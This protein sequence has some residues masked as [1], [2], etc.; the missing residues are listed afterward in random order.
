[1]RR[2]EGHEP[3][4]KGTREGFRRELRGEHDDR[5]F[6]EPNLERVNAFGKAGLGEIERD[7]TMDEGRSD[8]MPKRRPV[9][10]LGYP[11][12]PFPLQFDLRENAPCE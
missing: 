11:K 7:H 9:G 12:L 3:Q 4:R 1:M 2:V 8:Q 5:L 10:D 6:L